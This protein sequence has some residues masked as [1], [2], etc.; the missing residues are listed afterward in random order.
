MSSSSNRLIVDCDG[1]IADKSHGGDYSKASP[2][3]HG[4]EQV[5]K[6]YDS[7]YEIVLYTARYGDRENGNIHMQYER[8]YLEWTRW[9]EANNVK[10]HHA[11]MGKPA[12]VL[13]IDD[14]A[15]RVNGNS[16]EGWSE[17]WKE[18]SALKNKDKYGNSIE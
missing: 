14:K 5:N 3:L 17:V 16:E 7:G 2:M 8:G 12:G 6:L 4:I 9:L 1:V 13:Y 10:Y 18:I 11:F 15:A